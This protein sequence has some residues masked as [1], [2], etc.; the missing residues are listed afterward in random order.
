[1]SAFTA[2]LD[3]EFLE[4]ARGRPVLREG[5]TQWVVRSPLPYHVGA[6]DS[7]V[8]VTVPAGFVTDFASIPRL[9]WRFEAPAGRALKASVVHDFLYDRQGVVE[10]APCRL[11]R[12]SRAECDG[13]FLEAMGVVGVPRWKAL[14][15]WAA[16]RAFGWI[17]W[18][19]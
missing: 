16:V 2:H 12:F 5:R 18:G 10:T 19:R 3:V 11:E 9:F 7:D 8:V 1:M 17:G 6:E 13:V 4:D 15:L 14:I